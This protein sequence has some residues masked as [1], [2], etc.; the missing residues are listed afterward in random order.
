[1]VPLL[2]GERFVKLY[3]AREGLLRGAG[4]AVGVVAGALAMGLGVAFIYVNVRFSARES[5]K[6]DVKVHVAAI[7]S[8]PAVLERGR[9][10]VETIGNCAECHGS[11]LGG[12]I[13]MDDPTLGRLVAPNLTAGK[14]GIGGTFTDADWSAAILHG[15]APSGRPLHLMPAQEYTQLGDEDVGAI[16]AYVKSLPPVDSD[17]PATEVAL[18]AKV[19]TVFAGLPMFPAELV[20]HDA[21]RPQTVPPAATVEYGRYLTN[22]CTGCHKPD[23]SGGAMAGSPPDWPTVPNLTP[24]GDFGGWSEADLFRAMREGKRPD[25]A[26]LR[27]PMPWKALGGLSDDELRAIR[28]Y[29]KSLPPVATAG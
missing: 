12:S 10:L 11:D 23:F 6:Y 21:P 15:F 18:A 9:H 13:F 17:L 8:D 29:L 14:N 22:V 1:M 2:C 19:L 16:I 25:G 26:D 5:R 20:A 28:M 4:K 24:S 7:P 3:G 27:K